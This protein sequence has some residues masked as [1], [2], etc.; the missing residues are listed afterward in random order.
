MAKANFY[1]SDWTTVSV[2]NTD[3]LD[4]LATSLGVTQIV[5]KKFEFFANGDLELNVNNQ[6]INSYVK[7][8]DKIEFDENTLGVVTSCKIVTTGTQFRYVVDQ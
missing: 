4:A 8:G 3:I 1:S 5:A 2:A 7:S 6:V